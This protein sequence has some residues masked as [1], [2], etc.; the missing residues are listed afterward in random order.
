MRSLTALSIFPFFCTL[1]RYGAF[2]EKIA[3]QL[4]TVD[5]LR[6]AFFCVHDLLYQSYKDKNIG[7]WLY[8]GSDLMTIFCRRFP[9]SG[10]H[11]KKK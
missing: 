9:T 8:F 1:H 2:H 7:D 5:I 3:G 4:L 6:T 10:V 11:I